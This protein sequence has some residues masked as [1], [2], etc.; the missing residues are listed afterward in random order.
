MNDIDRNKPYTVEELLQ[1]VDDEIADI[2]S[3]EIAFEE[4]LAI[5]SPEDGQTT[6]ERAKA[7]L[8]RPERFPGEHTVARVWLIES[9]T[10]YAFSPQDEPGAIDGGVED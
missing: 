4:D 3:A 10:A 2:R 8:A 9:S 1:I 5:H 6:D 7:A